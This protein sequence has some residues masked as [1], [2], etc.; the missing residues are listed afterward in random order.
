MAIM[1]LYT[2]YGSPDL[3]AVVRAALPDGVELLTLDSKDPVELYEKFGS[4]DVV[5]LATKLPREAIAAAPRLK[6]V[7]HQGVGYQDTVDIAEMKARKIRL[8]LTPNGT[9]TGVA[10]HTVMLMLAVYKHLSFVDAELRRGNFHVQSMRPVSRHLKGR[11]IGYVG[12]GA[13]AQTVAELLRGFGTTGLYVD[14][15]FPLTSAREHELGVTR[16]DLDTVLRNC[17]VLTLHVPLTSTTK[18]LIGS[19]AI[20]KMRPGSILINTARGGIV[21]EIALNAALESGHLL[22]AGLDVYE[23]EPVVPGNVLGQRPNVVLTPHIAAGTADALREKM[24]TIGKNLARFR[25]GRPLLYE[26]QFG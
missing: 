14:P 10:E 11:V 8:A 24:A 22:G 19:E 5:I 1:A 2:A 25:D 12:M 26:V 9:I 17:D 18:H 13:I 20:G 23:Q 16:A 7:L 3:Y 21:D 15:H 6:L 4:A